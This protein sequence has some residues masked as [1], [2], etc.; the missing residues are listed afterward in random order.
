MSK[1][2]RLL[3]DLDETGTGKMTCFGSSMTPILKSG[4][5]LLFKRFDK[6]EIGDIV[7]C[8]VN[9]RFIDAHKITKIS[10]RGYMISN[11]KG[12]DNGW[13]KK[14]FGKVIKI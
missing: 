5:T 14:V 11:N 9:G 3:K 12:W 2:L 6:Y 1:Y 4:Q 10:H 7:F 8:K 13:T